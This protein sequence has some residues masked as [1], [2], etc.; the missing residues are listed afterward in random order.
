MLE[1]VNS[2]KV[3]TPKKE[4][5]QSVTSMPGYGMNF[6]SLL[7]ERLEQSQELKFSKHAIKRAEQRGID[8]STSL[9]ENLSGAVEKARAKGAKDVV[10]IAEREA[11]IINVPNNIVVTAMSGDE[12]K[13]N[14]FTNIDSA[15]LL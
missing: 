3:N 2:F 15:V 14:I 8:V 13:N 5:Y 11:F 6:E 4:S 7:K 10:I 12:I 9:L 1:A